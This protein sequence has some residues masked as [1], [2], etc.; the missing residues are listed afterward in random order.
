A[1]K[2]DILIAVS[3]SGTSQNILNACITAGNEGLKIITLSGFKA[4]NPLRKNGG[5]RFLD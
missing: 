3:S 1:K 5:Y 2:N 4:Y